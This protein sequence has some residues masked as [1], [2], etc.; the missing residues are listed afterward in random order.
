VQSGAHAFALG[1]DLAACLLLGWLV[2]GPDVRSRIGIVLLWAAGTALALTVP[3]DAPLHIQ[4]DDYQCYDHLYLQSHPGLVPPTGLETSQWIPNCFVFAL[5]LRLLG[6]RYDNLIFFSKLLYILCAPLGAMCSWLLFRDRLAAVATGVMFLLSP[7]LLRYAGTVTLTLPALALYLISVLFLLLFIGRRRVGYLVAATTFIVITI[8]TKGEHLLFG[9]S[10][11]L[12]SVAAEMTLVKPASWRG[13]RLSWSVLAAFLL[14]YGILLAARRHS[15]SIGVR[16][17]YHAVI[18]GGE[19]PWMLLKYLGIHTFLM[20]PVLV[21]KLLALWAWRSRDHRAIY[22][23]LAI[24]GALFFFIYSLA[25]VPMEEG[26][27]YAI[28]WMFPV[29]VLA[30]LGLSQWKTTH[31]RIVIP[32]VLILANVGLLL[33][34][35]QTFRQRPKYK[36]FAFLQ[37]TVDKLSDC[38]ILY[39]DYS[40]KD[41]SPGYVLWALAK[42]ENVHS[43]ESMVLPDSGLARTLRLY[44]LVHDADFLNARLGEW[45]KAQHTQALLEAIARS[46]PSAT[47]GMDPYARAKYEKLQEQIQA[48]GPRLAVDERRG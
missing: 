18:L 24:P 11:V 29:Y 38:K 16:S 13:L 1:V 30:G 31:G 6:Y 19:Y 23:A 9:L 25:Y 28:T 40:F 45:S 17:Y 47:D 27:R 12:L 21:E 26:G 33:A 43:I 48:A 41:S 35:I 22:L 46:G 37:K 14:F 5:P 10:Y 36:E 39:V 34:D 15:D 20:A 7:G 44:N 32:S 42:P 4:Y 8:S 3:L 2:Y